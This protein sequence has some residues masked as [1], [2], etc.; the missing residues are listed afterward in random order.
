M[1]ANDSS[2]CKGGDGVFLIQSLNTLKQC[3][4]FDVFGFHVMTTE[5]A[6]VLMSA[7]RFPL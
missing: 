7:S 4:Q 1:G 3:S 6:Y 2:L 5:A